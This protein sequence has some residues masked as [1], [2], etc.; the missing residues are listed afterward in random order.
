MKKVRVCKDFK[1]D[2]SNHKYRMGRIFPLKYINNK[3]IS[4]N[5]KMILCLNKNSRSTFYGESS[6]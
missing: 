2:W 5:Y 4:K 1:I 3:N 6:L